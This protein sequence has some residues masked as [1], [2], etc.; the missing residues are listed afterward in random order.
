MRSPLLERDHEVAV[1][2]GSLARASEGRGGLVA[3]EGPAG[4]GKTHLIDHTRLRAREAGW[5]VLDARCTPL[6]ETIGWCLLRDWFATHGLDGPARILDDPAGRGLGDLVYAA[7]WALEDLARSGPVLLLADDVQWADIGSLQA[8]DLLVSVVQDLPCLVVVAVRS[9]EAPAAPESLSRIVASS[10]VLAPR[11]LSVEAVRRMLAEEGIDRDPCELHEATGGVPFLVSESLHAEGVPETVVGS[12]AGRIARLSPTAMTTARAACL[13]CG[14]NDAT[15]LATVSGS[16]TATVADDVAAL[17]AA[18]LL[19][20][21]G[22]PRHP[23]IAQAVLAHAPAHELSELHRRAALLLGRRGASHSEVASHLLQTS[24]AGDPDVRRRLHEEGRHALVAGD[25]ELALRYLGRSLA[26]LEPEDAELVSDLARTHAELGHVDEAVACWEHAGELAG[27]AASVSTRSIDALIHGGRHHEALAVVTARPEHG[28]PVVAARLVITGLLAGMPA[29]RVHEQV[30]GVL[31]EPEHPATPDERLSAA[32]SAVLRVMDGRDAEGALDLALRAAGDGRLVEEETSDSFTVY[33]CSGV[34]TWTS[35]YDETRRLLTAALQD[36]RRRHSAIAFANASACRGPALMRMGNISEAIRD[37]DSALAQRE[38]GWHAYLGMV[39]GGLV[40]CRIARGEL[41]HATRLR[42]GLERLSHEASA[43]GA[44]ATM[45]LADLA[46]AEGHHERAAQLYAD[47]GALVRDRCDNPALLPW[48]AARALEVARLGAA[49][50]A[51]SLARENL[52]RA[53]AF[54]APYPVAQALRTIAAVDPAA[55][56]VPLLREALELLAPTGAERLSSQVAVDLAGRLVLQGGPEARP[57]AV[58][59]LRRAETLAAEQ[60][61]RPLEDRVQRL[62]GRLG[63]KPQ[64]PPGGPADRLTVSERRVADLA[65]SGLTNRQIAE[66]LFVT[67]KAVE[68]HLSNVYR[69]L[70]IRSRS[71]LPAVLQVPTPRAAP[72]EPV[73]LTR[74]R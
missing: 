69:K 29:A 53:R 16:P 23:L 14:P 7:R 5:R 56:Q 13:L 72:E 9:G 68:W 39:L 47:V 36:A 10:R 51:G 55:R 22:R 57:E 19:D 27:N 66:Q 38:H 45:S 49:T 62:L 15:A 63:E 64:L 41:H 24:P 34:L 43:D 31:L 33:L 1:L 61:L 17:V 21:D 54:G 71:R 70:G 2:G 60:E 25:H 50:E 37:F 59:L 58:T 26:E 8:L 6:S 74:H 48:R 20:P 35:A 42:A 52:E 3:I 11:P 65:A 30:D 12:V 67:V 32:A 44:Y 73:E 40:E 18:D 46:A 4:I 28:H